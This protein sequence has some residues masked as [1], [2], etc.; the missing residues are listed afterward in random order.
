MLL[1]QVLDV[2]YVMGI[3]SS[4][5]VLRREGQIQICCPLAP[6]F[7]EKKV[8]SNPSMSIGY[9][10]AKTTLFKCFACGESGKLWQLVD[11]YGT[12]AN[13]PDLVELADKLVV[14]DKPTLGMTIE[15]ACR[16]IK[17]WVKVPPRLR[18][19]NI[20]PDAINKR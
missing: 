10:E 3:S 18:R 14:D 1:Q 8:D 11:S 15:L 6:W 13:R 20:H 2:L 16:D 4:E 12:L 5:V 7:H 17:G 9:S 19:I